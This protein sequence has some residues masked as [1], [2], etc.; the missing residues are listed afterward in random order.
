MRQALKIAALVATCSVIQVARADITLVNRSTPD[1]G[2]SLALNVEVDNT[3]LEPGATYVMKLGSSTTAAVIR[4]KC[5][6]KGGKVISSNASSPRG[7]PG[8]YKISCS[9]NSNSVLPDR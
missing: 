6:E 7:N 2:R 8:R 4:Y 3:T 1:N 9:Y 5:V